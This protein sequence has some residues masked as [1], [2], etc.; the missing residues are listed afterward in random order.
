VEISMD[1]NDN[2]HEEETVA[3]HAVECSPNTNAVLVGQILASRS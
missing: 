3:A 2:N 1:D